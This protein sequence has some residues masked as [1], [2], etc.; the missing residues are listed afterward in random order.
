MAIVARD[1]AYL[2]SSEQDTAELITSL[3]ELSKR[4]TSLRDKLYQLVPA[5]DYEM[6]ASV[7][8]DIKLSLAQSERFIREECY[9]TLGHTM[10]DNTANIQIF[11]YGFEVGYE[12]NRIAIRTPSWAIGVAQTGNFKVSFHNQRP[13]LREHVLWDSMANKLVQDGALALRGKSEFTDATFTFFTRGSD[14]TRLLN[15]NV[16]VVIGALASNHLVATDAPRNLNIHLQWVNVDYARHEHIE[17]E[18]LYR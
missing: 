13:Y 8:E 3:V 10:I 14:Q 1:M 7:I 16:E 18:I 11:P 4:T 9:A 6:A 17:I 5:E 15:P 12:N 2:N